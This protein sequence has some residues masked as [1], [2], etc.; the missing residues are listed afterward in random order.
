MNAYL[1]MIA[2]TA[3]YSFTDK[4]FLTYFEP[5]VNEVVREW[6]EWSADQ[7]EMQTGVDP[8]LELLVERATMKLARTVHDIIDQQVVM[9]TA[10][11]PFSRARA[12]V[13][14]S[15]LDSI[16][17]VNLYLIVRRFMADWIEQDDRYQLNVTEHDVEYITHRRY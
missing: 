16:T 5:E 11:L 13:V 17:S 14:E 6:L 15:T 1:K 10:R 3:E 4:I 8:T 12:F 9:L 7:Y 2:D